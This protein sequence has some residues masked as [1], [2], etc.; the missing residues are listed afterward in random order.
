MIEIK[1]LILDDI[2]DDDLEYLLGEVRYRV[3]YT[4]GVGAFEVEHERR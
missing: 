2:E 1:I 4:D 3:T